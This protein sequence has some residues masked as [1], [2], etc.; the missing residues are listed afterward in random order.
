MCFKVTITLRDVNDEVPIFISPNETSVGENQPLNTLISV[1]KAVDE[2]EGRN[3][4]VEYILNN[5]QSTFSLG[6]VDGLLRVNG[7]LDR[8]TKSNYTLSVKF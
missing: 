6:S 5:E 2:D 7:L 1:V 8:E 3:G 4:Y